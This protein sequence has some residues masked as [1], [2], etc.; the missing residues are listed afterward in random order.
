MN[1]TCAVW[2][3]HCHKPLDDR[4]TILASEYEKI[5]IVRTVYFLFGLKLLKF[6]GSQIFTCTIIILSVFFMKG[7]YVKIYLFF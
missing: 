5:D 7:N 3:D 1:K 2:L 6:S 4:Y